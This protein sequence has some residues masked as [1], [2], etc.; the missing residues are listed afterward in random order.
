MGGE[1]EREAVQRCL[2]T[3]LGRP[4][5]SFGHLVSGN[6]GALFPMHREARGWRAHIT[7]LLRSTWIGTYRDRHS[8]GIFC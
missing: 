6:E 4:S 8:Q 3:E 2:I 1:R 7:L 5:R